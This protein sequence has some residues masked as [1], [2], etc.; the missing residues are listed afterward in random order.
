[1]NLKLFK[2]KNVDSTNDIAIKIIKKDKKTQGVVFSENQKKGRGRYG[3]KWISFKGNLFVSIFY[4]IQSINLTLKQFS[5]LNGN[6]ILG[7]LS[8]YSKANFQLKHPNDIVVNKKK[9]CG[10]LQEIVEVNNV[11]YLIVGIG[12]NL[13][14][15]PIIN[16]YGTT[17]LKELTNRNINT[18]QVLKKLMESYESFLDDIYSNR[19]NSFKKIYKKYNRFK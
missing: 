9:I 5:I 3:N 4:N 18:N 15:K 8:K 6:M 1:M 17:S 14:K 7:L 10:I 2:Y 13:I 19:F 16:N 11:K 12:V